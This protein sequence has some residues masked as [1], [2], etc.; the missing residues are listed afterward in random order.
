MGKP[1]SDGNPENTKKKNKHF[2]HPFIANTPEIQEEMLTEIGCQSVEDLYVDIPKKFR[3]EAPLNLPGPHPE[4][5]VYRMLKQLLEKN[6]TVEDMLLFLGAG[7]WPHYI[8]AHVSHLLQRSEFYTSYTPYQPEISQGMLQAIF[9][10]QS[11][12][13]EL[14]NLDVA[15]ASLYDWASALGEAVLMA[16]RIT[17]RDEVVVPRIIHPERLQTL[18][19]YCCGPGL[20]VRMVGYNRGTGQ[21]DT[22]ELEEMVTKETAAVYIENPNYLGVL[23]TGVSEVSEIAHSKGALLIVGVDPTSLGI[24]KPPGDYG[25]DIVVGEGQPLG[26]PMSFGGPLLGIF[27]CRGDMKLVRMM[28]GRVV[29]M[30]NEEKGGRRG[31]VLTLQT[32]EQHIRREKATSN[33]C[34]NEGLCTLAAAVYL[35][36]IGPRGMVQLG[37]TILANTA[38]AVKRLS[39]I[40][41]LET[42]LFRSTH[43]KE[44]T[45]S[46][47]KSGVTYPQLHTNLLKKGI[48][49]GKPIGKEFPELGENSALFCVTE[50][51]TKQDIDKLVSS[52][53][54]I[55]GEEG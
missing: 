10:Y 46:T 25:A 24:V 31:F 2:R 21:L 26:V 43:F 12:I 9:E 34:T 45:L 41:G 13:C 18:R 42:P 54:E 5:F 36:S 14:V 15:N 28:P 29:G 22:S 52:V 27:A 53:A 38:Y 33:I 39:E 47:D 17:K 6:R 32:R 7:C 11:M 50:I 4:M 30:T 23:E 49:G 37:K 55:L 16:A 3:V 35:S 44:F 40:E 51:H 48:H 1:K 19:S 8:P 20:K